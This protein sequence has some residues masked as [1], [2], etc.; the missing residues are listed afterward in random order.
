MLHL[1]AQQVNLCLFNHNSRKYEKASVYLNGLTW[2][3]DKLK[4]P[5]D[6]N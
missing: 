1:Q 4:F 6:I 3:Y 5:N 2:I